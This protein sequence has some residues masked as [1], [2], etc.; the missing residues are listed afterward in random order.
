MLLRK[1]AHPITVREVLSHTSGLPFKSAVEEPTLDGLPL[2]RAVRSY[3]HDAAADSS[4]ARKYKYSNAGINTAAR[5]IEVVSGM[6]YEDFMQ[7]APLRSAR[8]EGH[9]LLAERRAGRRASPNPTSP[10]AAKTDLDE[11]PIEPTH[12]SAHRP[13]APLP[14]PAGG[15]FSTASDTASS[16]RCCSTAASSN[17]RRI[18][19]AKPP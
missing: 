19:C 9:D 15:L 18:L 13:R 14:M 12:L 3:A 6:T 8:D 16:A 17:G 5:I 2:P 4:P 11:T 1:P 7:Q 10:N